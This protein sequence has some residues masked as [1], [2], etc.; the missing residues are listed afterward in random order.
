MDG[1]QS[2]PIYL[3]GIGLIMNRERDR[4]EDFTELTNDDQQIVQSDKQ[5]KIVDSDRISLT[6]VSH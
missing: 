4:L 2:L 5:I 1:R 6:P 3:P